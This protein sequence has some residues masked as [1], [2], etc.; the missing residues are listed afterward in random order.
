MLRLAEAEFAC[1]PLALATYFHRGGLRICYVEQQATAM[2]LRKSTRN[3]QDLSLADT[4]P[5]RS[6]LSSGPRPSA[7][8]QG[9]G[10]RWLVA[11]LDDRLA[12]VSNSPRPARI[13]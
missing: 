13:P 2:Q 1:V 6:C 12:L 4:P 11:A 3:K 10:T 9:A 7:L 5:G 8:P